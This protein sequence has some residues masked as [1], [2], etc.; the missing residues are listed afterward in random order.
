M[1]N[2]ISIQKLV[3]DDGWRFILDSD[4]CFLCD[5][6]SGTRISSF[7]REGGLLLLDASTRQCLVSRRTCSKEDRV[8]RLHQQMGHPPFYLLR[9]CYPSLFQGVSDKLLFCEACHLAKLRRMSYK[10]MDDRCSSPFDCI[11]SDI[12]GPCPVES[13]TRCQ[14]FIVFIDDYSR[15][16]WLHL[17]KTKGEAPR[18]IVQFC[19][20]IYNQFGKKVKRFRSDNGTEFINNEVQSYFLNNGILH[21]SSCVHTPQQN[22]LAERRLG[23]T[24]ATA[25][26]L[27]FQANLTKKF[28]GEA[29]LTA[30]FLIN[31]IPM[32]VI[33]YGP[34]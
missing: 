11:H 2:L 27:L 33:D 4:D 30:S 19:D 21:E 28:W 10:S 12:W 1:A 9:T 24:L 22:G 18:K 25:R 29:V 13:L 7:R 34:P 3:D 15:T 14:Y 20:M 16:M 17:L 23:Y 5:K 26:S 32:K 8:I 31:R 6:V